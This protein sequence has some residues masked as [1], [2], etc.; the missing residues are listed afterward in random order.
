[1]S[2]KKERQ[3]NI[4]MAAY[5]KTIDA[6]ADELIRMSDDILDHPE[7]PYEEFR[8]SKLL[9]D[10]LEK[11]GFSVDRG[12]ADLPT[13]FKATWKNG[14]GGPVVG[15][16]TEED[17]LPNGHSCGHNMQGPMILGAAY[18]LTQAELKEPFTLVVYCTP[19]EEILTGKPKMIEKGCFKE[20]DFMLQTHGGSV[21]TARMES[22]TGEDLMVEFKGIHAHDTAAPWDSRNGFDAFVLAS[23]GMEFLRGKVHDGTR[24]F[25]NIEDGKGIKGNV[26]PSYCRCNFR[27]RTFRMEDKAD[28]DKR[29]RNIIEGAALMAG[30]EVKITRTL[31]IMGTLGNKTL[32][33]LW[34]E[35]ARLHGAR[36]VVE[37]NN[38]TG[39]SNDFANITQ[40]LPGSIVRIASHP[41]G[42]AGHSLEYLKYSKDPQA[43][44]ET[45]IGSKTVAKTCIDLITRPEL[46]EAVKEEFRSRRAELD[47]KL[48]KLVI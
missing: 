40:M 10:W 5:D 17:A 28:I 6:L 35:N 24:I 34:M 23:N 27:F 12:I 11:H 8:T 39:G 32:G 41:L 31:E 1:M 44:E 22:L 3:G 2:L 42:V 30:V 15:L 21:A 38:H 19:A 4:I 9:A 47:E 25:S 7:L 16:I 14:K 29:M 36:N 37:N 46:L 20:C 33:K 13:A 43:H 45:I 18:A 26:D 48:A